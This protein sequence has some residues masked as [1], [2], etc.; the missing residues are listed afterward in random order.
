MELSDYLWR[1]KC[2]GSRNP[3]SCK[4]W[5]RDKSGV[6]TRIGTAGRSV[7]EL[8]PRLQCLLILVGRANA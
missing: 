5:L 6:P 8:P 7:R 1:A 2:R 4:P 3:K